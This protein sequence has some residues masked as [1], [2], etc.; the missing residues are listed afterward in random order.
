VRDDG[1][2]TWAALVLA[3]AAA[4]F[5]A[6]LSHGDHGIYWPD[7]IYQ[8]LEPAHRLVFGHGFV[9]W[10]FIDGARSWAFPALVAAVIRLA[11]DDPST[12]LG[13]VRAAFLL[14]AAG[15]TYAVFRLARALGAGG[16]CALAGAAAFAFAG[17][18]AYFGHRALSETASALPVVLG[19]SLAL[20]SLAL[21][22]ASKGARIRLWLGAS[23]LGLAVL[24]RLQNGLFCLGLL[25]LLGGRREWRRAGEALAVLSVWAVA[26]GALDWA[27]WGRPFHSALQYLKFNLVEGKASQW[28]TAPFGWYAAVL[29]RG[30]P[31]LAVLLGAFSLA[32]ARR[33]PALLCTAVAFFLLHALIPHKELRFLLPVIPLFCALAASGMHAL[34]SRLHPRVPG[35]AALGLALAALASAA[36]APGLTF[37]HL[38][39]YEGPRSK[40]SAWDDYGDVNRLLLRASRQEDL[41]GLKVEGVHPAWMGGYAYLHQPVPLYG[42]AG[43]SR[44]SRRFNYVI[45]SRDERPG[46]VVAHDGPWALVKLW[47]GCVED[48]GF[49]WRLP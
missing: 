25:G 38:G 45:T 21:P 3:A 6:V 10:E 41:C 48:P 34:S 30:M 36:R 5:R 18:I 27:T 35:I 15:T 23:L 26:F 20:E 33:A 44:E 37:W 22:R 14:V 47:D 12:Y 8:S 29:W 4:L 13:A 11:G 1:R 40:R 7:E 24:L 43:P 17:P 2:L 39:A 42:A 46:M 16:A 28:G 49:S 31:L 32:A 19:F 9:P